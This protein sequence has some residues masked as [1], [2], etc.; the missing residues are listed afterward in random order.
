MTAEPQ[1]SFRAVTRSDYEL[2]YALGRAAFIEH[3]IATYG[4]WDEAWQRERFDT[5]FRP[6]TTSIIVS[7]GRDVGQLAVEWDEDPVFLAVITLLPEAR[8]RGIGTAVIRGVLE[9]AREL[10]KAVRLQV[11]VVN[12]DARRLYERLG[13]RETGTNETHV[14][15]LWDLA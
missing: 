13:F 5:Y 12:P 14:Q 3:V 9:R 15:M 1:W 2:V 4:Q 6:E 10:G 8:G 11:F 7:D